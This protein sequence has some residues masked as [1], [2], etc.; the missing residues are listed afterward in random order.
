VRDDLGRIRPAPLVVAASL[1]AVEGVLVLVYAVL[2]AVN[3]H[4]DRVTMG[5]STALFFAA[6]GLGLVACAWYLVHGLSWARSPV[7]VT[8]VLALGLAW[9]FV[10]GST[11]WVAVVL[12]VVALVV[13]A[14]L[15]H[16]ASLDALGGRH[17]PGRQGGRDQQP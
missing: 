7:V 3:V 16:P 8:Q 17:D 9:N 6:L 10:G 15:L 1:T 14:G 5:V 2:E 11:T 13:L 12:A 4:S